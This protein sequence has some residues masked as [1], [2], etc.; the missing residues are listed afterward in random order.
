MVK[1]ASAA[2]ELK[3]PKCVRRVTTALRRRQDLRN[4]II[5]V[6]LDFSA[7]MEL[8]SQP[9]LEIHVPR[10]TTV[11]LVL[12][13]FSSNKTVSTILVGRLTCQLD[14]RR[15]QELM[16]R[17]QRVAYSS[18]ILTK[19]TNFCLVDWICVIT[20][21]SLTL[22][23]R[24]NLRQGFFSHNS[25]AIVATSLVIVGAYRLKPL[26]LVKYLQISTI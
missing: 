24:N 5:N 6:I 13:T 21:L 15:A 11:H 19:I 12:A 2:L 8:D 4:T 1:Y 20:S 25:M 14:A 16:D 7:E 26:R 10:H 18:A 23:L 3:T 22:L 17:I 9:V